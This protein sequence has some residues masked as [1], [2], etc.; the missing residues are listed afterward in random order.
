MHTLPKRFL[1]LL[2]LLSVALIACSAGAKKKPKPADVVLRQECKGANALPRVNCAKHVTP[3]FDEQGVLWV[4]W[5]WKGHI[6][7]NHSK[8]KGNTFSNP[9]RVSR[10]KEKIDQNG[11]NRP[12]VMG[13]NGV[14]FVT[15]IIKGKIK[16]TGKLM[17]SRST[18]GGKTFSPPHTISTAKGPTSER[19]ETLGITPDGTL[20]LTWLDKRELLAAR[21]AKKPYIGSAIYFATSTD[22]GVSFSKDQRI[23]EHTC[24]C[25]RVG[26]AF[27]NKGNPLVLWRH[28]FGEDVRDHAL[29][30]FTGLETPGEVRRLSKDGWNL[31]ACP[32][33]GPSIAYDNKQRLHAIWYTGAPGADGV[34]YA[35]SDDNGKT[36]S[37]K[38]LVGNSRKAASHGFILFHQGRLYIAWKEFDGKVAQ[39]MVMTSSDGGL[40]WSTPH[41]ALTTTNVSDHPWL[42]T[43]GK[44]VFASWQAG[45][46]GYRITEV[47]P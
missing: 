9:V 12:K 15:Y 20:F 22:G 18:D 8:D 5:S 17:F 23:A 41:V 25:C 24:E 32:H 27:D 46:E 29:S 38:L 14:L 7:V 2:L 42:V 28:I 6:F 40:N 34:Y 3:W 21:Q 16:F 36:F 11:E 39:F 31:K 35:N 1:F 4:A 19:F 13:N 30:H 45:L 10:Q 43:D 44:Q 26:L 47:Q 33:H 37:K